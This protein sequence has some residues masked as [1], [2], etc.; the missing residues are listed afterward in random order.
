V[1]LLVF[2]EVI[3]KVTSELTPLQAFVLLILILVLTW[4]V[5]IVVVV[6]ALKKRADTQSKA[7]ASKPKQQKEKPRQ[8]P[9]IVFQIGPLFNVFG[10]ICLVL[11]SGAVSWDYLSN[12]RRLYDAAAP[13]PSTYKRESAGYLAAAWKARDDRSIQ[14][15]W[16]VANFSDLTSEGRT[17]YLVTT[18]DHRQ[19]WS[20]TQIATSTGTYVLGSSE[21]QRLALIVSS[22]SRPVEGTL[23]PS[24]VTIVL[25][26]ELPE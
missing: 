16:F 6:I 8:S 4:S 26:T 21:G 10:V 15:T 5:T 11:L 23:A 22:A 3:E 14:V 20:K 2:R 18:A 12:G 25:E 24:D 13:P 17:L 1:F 9:L 19:F 7:V